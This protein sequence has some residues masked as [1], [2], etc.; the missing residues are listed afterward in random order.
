MLDN[1]YGQTEVMIDPGSDMLLLKAN[2]FEELQ[3]DSITM[4]D[5]D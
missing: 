5:S 2:L 3:I 1:Y 4:K